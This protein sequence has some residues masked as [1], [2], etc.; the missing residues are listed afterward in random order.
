M[1]PV[2]RRYRRV[3]RA[4]LEKRCKLPALQIELLQAGGFSAADPAVLAFPDG[5]EAPRS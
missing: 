1:R 5:A 3:K 2:E 4:A